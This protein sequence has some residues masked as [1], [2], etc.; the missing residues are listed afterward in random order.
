MKTRYRVGRKEG[1]AGRAKWMGFPNL[2]EMVS[3]CAE[4][5]CRAKRGDGGRR[6]ESP[7]V[8]A[9]RSLREV[10]QARQIIDVNGPEFAA[11]H[12]R[13]LK[14][15]RGIHGIHKICS[16]IFSTGP[17]MLRDKAPSSK[18]QISTKVTIISKI[19]TKNLAG[20]S[21]TSTRTRTKRT[22]FG[23]FR[24]LGQFGALQVYKARLC[25]SIG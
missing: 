22:G 7:H 25:F 18:L 17:E 21:R 3:D 16:V 1:G 20:G 5:R 23:M 11:H 13:N 15:I 10:G 24:Q 9:S 8:T 19:S 2:P 6:F 12:I 4:R 14:E